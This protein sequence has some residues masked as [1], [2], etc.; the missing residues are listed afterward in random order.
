[1]VFDD[2]VA[3]F[4]RRGGGRLHVAE[5]SR[6]S[7]RTARWS[8]GSA[9]P[10]GRSSRSARRSA[11]PRRNRWKRRREPTR[12]DE[13]VRVRQGSLGTARPGGVPADSVAAVPNPIRVPPAWRRRA[14]AAACGRRPRRGRPGRRGA[15]PPRRRSRSASTRTTPLRGVPALR[16]AAG[17]KATRVISVYVTGGKT[18]DPRV[19]ALARRTKARLHGLVDA[20][21]REGRHRAS[22]ATGWSGRSAAPRT[23][24]WWRS[25]RQLRNLRPAPILRP[26]PEPNTTW[27]AWSGHGEPQ[28]PGRVRVA[29]GRRCGRRSA[30]PAASGSCSSG[31]PTRGASRTRPGTPS[32]RTSRAS[33]RSTWWG[34]APT[35]SATSAG[36]PGPSRTRCSRTP[37]AQISALAPKPF[38]I[39]ET[40]SSAAG[41]SRE[42][43]IGRLPGLQIAIPNLAGVVWFDVRDRNGDFRVSHARGQPG[44]LRR[45]RAEGRPVSP[46]VAPPPRRRRLHRPGAGRRP[47]GADHR[48]GGPPDVAHRLRPHRRRAA[49]S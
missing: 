7:S 6:R 3:A 24:A 22:R 10:G 16:A 39:A 17:P 5:R 20:R 21:R 1:M 13:G 15:S 38:W 33:R 8:A 26:M 32:P 44:G 46:R 49:R 25:T 35:T 34:R 48:D 2:P 11:E 29:P 14:A 27:Y 19:I 37:T 42:R 45:L 18:V 36:S 28:H 9:T 23:A 47:G 4:A 30:R 43:W 12:C 40:G 41:G 31:R